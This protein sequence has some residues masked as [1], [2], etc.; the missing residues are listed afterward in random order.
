MNIR[1]DGRKVARKEL[2]MFLRV[3]RGYRE[4]PVDSFGGDN[5]PSQQLYQ[6]TLSTHLSRYP[7]KYSINP[8]YQPTLPTHP[9]RH[10]LILIAISHLTL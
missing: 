10:H 3:F 9:Q 5:T 7:T 4:M 2:R 1:L 6:H 8:L